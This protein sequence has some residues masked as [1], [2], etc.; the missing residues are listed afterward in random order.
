MRKIAE[1]EYIWRGVR[2]SDPP[3]LPNGRYD[4]KALYR[5]LQALH[6]RRK[7]EAEARQRRKHKTAQ[8]LIG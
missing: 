5:E 3:K 7:R 4:T 2:Y 1:G 6:A 8:E